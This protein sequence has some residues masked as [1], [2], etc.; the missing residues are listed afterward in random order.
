MVKCSV[1]HHPAKKPISKLS[2]LFEGA[3]IT[4]GA[5]GLIDFRSFER[6]LLGSA[7]GSINGLAT[8]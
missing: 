2:G 5:E 4:L 1:S 7:A 8:F 6:L 3:R